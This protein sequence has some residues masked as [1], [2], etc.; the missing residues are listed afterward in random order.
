M[1]N[2]LSDAQIESKN[3]NVY[4]SASSG[5][6]VVAPA[7]FIIRI[8]VHSDNIMQNKNSPVCYRKHRTKEEKPRLE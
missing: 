8:K 6:T 2:N 5:Q 4:A 1:V 3:F 7:M